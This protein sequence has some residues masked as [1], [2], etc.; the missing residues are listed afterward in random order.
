MTASAWLAVGE[1]HYYPDVFVTCG[2]DNPCGY[3]RTDPTVIIEVQGRSTSRT[4]RGEK[5][6]AYRRLPSLREYVLVWQDRM[7]VEV[8]GVDG[9]DVTVLE[10]EHDVL[11][12]ASIEFE[13]TLADIHV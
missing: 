11:G 10:E 2:Q 4:D 6:L 3:V 5:R 7:Q 12:L 8:H 9:D 1:D 13:M